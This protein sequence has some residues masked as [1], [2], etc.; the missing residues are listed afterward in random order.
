MIDNVILDCAACHQTQDIGKLDFG[1]MR[2]IEQWAATVEPAE[3]AGWSIRVSLN[4][5]REAFCPTCT[6]RQPE[7]TLPQY[8]GAD[9]ACAKCRHATPKTE[10]RQRGKIEFLARICSNCGFGWVEAPADALPW[11]NRLLRR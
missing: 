1:G 2:R 7:Q 11:W 5:L 8:S 9:V 10:Y 6:A 3:K 4:G